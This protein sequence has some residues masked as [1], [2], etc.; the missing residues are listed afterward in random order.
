MAE[1]LKGPRQEVG[2]L[3]EQVI[4]LEERAGGKDK[5][6]SHTEDRATRW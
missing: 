3:N 2:D 5:A 4:A 1:G 6:G